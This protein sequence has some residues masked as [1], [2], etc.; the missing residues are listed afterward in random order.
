LA[1]RRT[2]SAVENDSVAANHMRGVSVSHALRMATL[3]IKIRFMRESAFQ[4]RDSRE[5]HTCYDS[6]LRL[7]S[8]K[9]AY[10]IIAYG[11]GFHA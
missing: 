4:Q 11:D 5:H 1:A 10:E 8:V 7:N 3:I 9:L 6:P 2:R